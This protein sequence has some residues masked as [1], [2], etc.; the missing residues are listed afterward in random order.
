VG[1]GIAAGVFNQ[2][3][4]DLRH[5]VWQSNA[6]KSI[7]STLEVC[8]PSLTHL[9]GN[10]E[11]RIE[12]ALD[13]A[14]YRPYQAAPYRSKASSYSFYRPSGSQEGRD[15]KK[16]PFQKKNNNNRSSGKGN[17]PASKK[18]EGQKKKCPLREA[19]G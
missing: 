19:G 18:G 8:K 11:D 7:R 15:Y 17:G 14:K 3:I 5:Q 1:S 10:D 4:E 6:A 16:K 2:G 12:K 13:A 9:F